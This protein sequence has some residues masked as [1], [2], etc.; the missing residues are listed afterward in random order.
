MISLKSESLF[1]QIETATQECQDNENTSFFEFDRTIE[2]IMASF[3]RP[4]KPSTVE[5]S[6]SF[7]LS[8]LHLNIFK[9][10]TYKKEASIFG[11]YKF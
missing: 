4:W 3:S 8:S 10:T 6:T 9:K 11:P 5:I 7:S 2:M 1:I